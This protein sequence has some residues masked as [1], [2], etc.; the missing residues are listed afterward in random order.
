MDPVPYPCCDS[1]LQ[2]AARNGQLDVI[3]Y[4]L[5]HGAKLDVVAHPDDLTA[6]QLALSQGHYDIVDA[7]QTHSASIL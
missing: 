6:T 3:L 4:L 5:E 2:A 7:L 1:P